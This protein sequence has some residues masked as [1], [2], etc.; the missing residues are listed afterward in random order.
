MKILF[1]NAPVFFNRFENSQAPLG[2]SYMASLLLENGFQEVRIKDY[3][4]ESF[5]ENEFLSLI[6]QYFPEIIGFSCRTASYPSAVKLITLLQQNNINA[7]LVLGGHHATALTDAVLKETKVDYIIRHE[8]ERTFLELVRTLSEGGDVERVKGI[9]FIKEGVLC[10]TPPRGLIMDL[11]TLPFPARELLPMNKYAYSVLLSSRGCPFQCVYCDKN[12]ST[13]NVHY[14]SVENVVDEIEEIILRWK[15]DRIYFI[16]D[17]FLL[18]KKRFF[19]ITDEWMRRGLKFEWLFQAR[20]DAIDK[21]VLTRAKASGCISIIFGV[22]SGDPTELEF[23]SKGGSATL[24]QGE[25]AIRLTREAGIASR[26][27]FMLGFPVSTHETVKNSIK[28]AKNINAEN[29]RF[30]HVVP[31]PNTPLWDKCVEDKII[32]DDIDWSKFNFNEAMIA[33]ND[34]SLDDL[35]VYAGAAYFHVFKWK[36]LKEFTITVIFNFYKFLKELPKR[37]KISSSLFYSF[38]AFANMASQ[39]WFL[40]GRMNFKEK[41]RYLRNIIVTERNL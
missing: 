3:E 14:R 38:P 21:E 20:V 36:V 26:T 11:D 5:N 28:Y 23:L 10:H 24:E 12:V 17:H 13:R 7:L 34:L 6:K 9:S 22:E 1:V 8:G 27:N 16:D 29:Y 25:K 19:E 37:K 18:N 39:I 30:F 33:T 4:V 15:K 2:I 31:L 32:S 40:M 35:Q 41:M